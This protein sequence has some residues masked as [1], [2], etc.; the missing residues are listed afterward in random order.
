ML[1]TRD[2]DHDGDEHAFAIDV[3]PELGQA[4]DSI[5]SDA[6]AAKK[7][8][9]ESVKRLKKMIIRLRIGLIAML[10]ATGFNLYSG[11]MNLVAYLSA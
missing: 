6:E 11:I 9:E 4:I 5:L 8:A 2:K 1:C 3:S 7:N 10:A